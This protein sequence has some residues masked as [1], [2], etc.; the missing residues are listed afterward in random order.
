MAAGVKRDGSGMLSGHVG[1]LDAELTQDRPGRPRCSPTC[2]NGVMPSSLSAELCTSREFSLYSA[3]LLLRTPLLVGL[4][5]AGAA[6]AP[7]GVAAG[8]GVA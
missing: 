1:A 6:L 5:P 8:P 4:S 7:G 3:S 2:I